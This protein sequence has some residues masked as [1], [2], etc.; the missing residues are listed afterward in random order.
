MIAAMASL[1]TNIEVYK[2]VVKI[3][4]ENK[5]HVLF[6]LFKSGKVCSV[7][8]NDNL[9]FS[10]NE[11]F[12]SQSSDENYAG[13]LLEKALVQLHFDGN[14]QPAEG[15]CQAFVFTS[16]TNFLYESF[17]GYHSSAYKIHDVIR[18]GLNTGSLM[19]VIFREGSSEV[20]LKAGVS[21]TVIDVS[22]DFLKVYDVSGKIELVYKEFFFQLLEYFEIC[23]FGNKV[24]EM[25]QIKTLVDLTDSW[26]DLDEGKECW[27][28]CYDL[29][30][31]ENDTVMLLNLPAKLIINMR[32]YISSEETEVTIKHPEWMICSNSSI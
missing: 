23:C 27:C 22:K 12:Y 18:H 30:V 31:E 17:V 26:C 5:L 9:A 24:F 8:V 20:E 11:L 2:R 25:P 16:L 7:V 15:V 19:C 21:Y 13:P 6:S 4:V 1:A 14:Y 3:K 28:S 32:L 29:L 10:F